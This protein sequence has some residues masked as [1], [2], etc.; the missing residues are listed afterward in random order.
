MDWENFVDALE[1]AIR[2]AQLVVR[3]RAEERASSKTAFQTETQAASESNDRLDRQ[4]SRI[5]PTS[6][7]KERST[8]ECLA[9]TQR[10]RYETKAQTKAQKK[11]SPQAKKNRSS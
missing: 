6:S 11:K 7:G 5:I 10:S 8:N 4:G 1:K 9:D 2:A 3:G